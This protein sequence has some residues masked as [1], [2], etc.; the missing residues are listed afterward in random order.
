MLTRGAPHR[1]IEGFA[2]ARIKVL[3]MLTPFR[4]FKTLLQTLVTQRNY[5]LRAREPNR[6]R[7]WLESLEDRLAPATVSD[8]GTAQLSIVLGANENLVIAS[9]GTSYFIASNQVFSATSGADPVNQGTAFSGLG[10]KA[11]T[12]ISA[13]LAQY[14]TGI[15]MSDAGGSASVTFSDSGT[16]TYA[17]NFTIA[18]SNAAAGTITFNGNTNFGAFNLQAATTRSILVNR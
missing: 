6:V 2:L 8:G 14:A 16:N 18:L 15:N 13:G 3:S 12:L 4:C 10:T 9:A 7:P 1:S 17:N 5:Q 11:L